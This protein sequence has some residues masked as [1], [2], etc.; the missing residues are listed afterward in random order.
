MSGTILSTTSGSN[1]SVNSQKRIDSSNSK[2][3]SSVLRRITAMLVDAAKLIL[4][5]NA[6]YLS[7]EEVVR[8][9]NR[10]YVKIKRDDL[11]GSHD[12]TIDIQTPEVN[13]AIAQDLGMILQTGQQTLPP[14]VTMKIWSRIL[15]LK[16]Q[17][18]LSRELEVYQPE[19]DPKQQMLMD[20]QIEE[21]RLKIEKAK[22]DI[23]EVDSR[24]HERVSRVIENEKDVDN[25]QSQ[26]LLR[27]QQAAESAARTKKLEAETDHLDK[28]F[29]DSMTGNKRAR[30]LEDKEIEYGIKKKE[31]EDDA[32]I[33]MTKAEMMVKIKQL[34]AMLTSGS[35]NQST[36]E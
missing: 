35:K 4:P 6:A 24:I 22:K 10:E 2:R 9:T 27:Q 11:A 13:N 3:E 14:P 32:G 7:E 15:K 34:E 30:E 36:G 5:M 17:Y 8:N 26:N 12:I 21:Q 33:E 20:M 16:G 29:V 1:Q 25:K 23:E 28:D 19:P 31:K 18:D